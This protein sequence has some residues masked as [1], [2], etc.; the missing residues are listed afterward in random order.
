[1]ILMVPFPAVSDDKHVDRTGPEGVIFWA[2]GCSR[3]T[4]EIY[5][6]GNLSFT[7]RTGAYH[8]ENM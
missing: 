3:E 5:K 6:H 1:M 8:F 2:H 4:F 7:P